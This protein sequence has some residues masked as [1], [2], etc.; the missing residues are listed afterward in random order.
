MKKLITLALAVLMILS[1]GACASTPSDTADTGTAA[2][3]K[4]DAGGDSKGI[5]AFSAYNMSWEYYVTLSKGVEDAA[6]AA[7]YDYVEHDQQSDQSIMLQGCTD[8]LNQGIACLVLTPCKPEA[9]G[10]IYKLA[11]EKEI[12]V[13]L[14]DIQT[15]ESGYLAV[16]KTD[17]YDG[18]V[19]AADYALEALKGKEESKKF[20]CITVNPSN[21]NIVRSDGFHDVMTENGWT[22]AAQLSGDSEPDVAYS[23]MQDILTA[24]P[25]VRIVFCSNDPM[26]IAASQ[27]IADAGLTP[28]EDVYVI[29]YDAQT[30]VFEPIE[31]GEILGTVAQDP[32]GM[33]SGS[34]EV[35]LQHLNGEEI[36]YDDASENLIYTDLWMI[37]ASNV[38]EY[39]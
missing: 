24:N 31:A 33:G 38:A 22:V 14:A 37:D 8:M 15:E 23:C 1:L 30:N 39:K 6:T 17:N 7:G 20:A 35:F 21:T 13:V 34:V 28:G 3:D 19:L 32:Y 29:G 10:S 5:I 26:A 25:D 9:V 18:G 27:A 36:T 4:P 11:A 12:P 2:T 16:L